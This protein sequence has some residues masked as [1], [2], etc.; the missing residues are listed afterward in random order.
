V[1]SENLPK[2]ITYHRIGAQAKNVT[3]VSDEQLMQSVA[4]GDLDAFNIIV[5]RYQH[6]AWR[7]ACRLLG[8]AMEAEDVAQETFLKILKAAPRYRSTARFCTY[9]YTI[10]YRLCLDTRKKSRP[11]LMD[12]IPDRPSTSPSAV[13]TLVARE[14]G[15]EIRHALES[16]P[17]N[18]RTAIVLKHDEGLSYAEIAQVMDISLKSVEML[19]RRAREKL[20]S[21][22]PHLKKT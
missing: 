6:H 11:S 13:E 3:G 12:P 8:D 16:L 9:L 14:C 20:Q 19:I 21:K 7:T 1:L 15:E 2:T 17:L 18:Q 22:L 10:I 4:G 5:L